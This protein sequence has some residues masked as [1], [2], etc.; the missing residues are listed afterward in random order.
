M[1]AMN[2]SPANFVPKTRKTKLENDAT[3]QQAVI[4]S[5]KACLILGMNLIK[6]LGPLH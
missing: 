2:C 5:V 3:L 6:T 1:V 4:N